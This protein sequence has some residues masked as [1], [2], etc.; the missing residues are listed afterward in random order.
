MCE[1]TA[2]TLGIKGKQPGF[3]LYIFHMLVLFG[4]FWIRDGFIANLERKF[5]EIRFLLVK[6]H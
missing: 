1:A 6:S 3:T 2:G 4:L 5:L